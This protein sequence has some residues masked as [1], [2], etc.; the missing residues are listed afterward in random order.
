MEFKATDHSY[1]CNDAN[2]YKSGVLQ[3]FEKWSDFRENYLDE[4]LE[5]DHDFNHCF[6]FD[7]KPLFNHE[8]DEDYTDRFSLHL[9]MMQQ[10]KGNFVPIEIKEIVKEDMPEI[11]KYL[12]SCWEYM[13]NQWEELR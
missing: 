13:K 6:R 2:Y 7:V 1:Y 11:E 10:R 8:K 5:L 4:N 9:Y 12:S 3:R